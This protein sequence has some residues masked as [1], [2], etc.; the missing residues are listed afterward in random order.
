M[1]RPSSPT[2]PRPTSTYEALAPPP[3]DTWV[4]ISERP[5]PVSA[6]GEWAVLPGCGAAVTFTGT[7]R[8]H[9]EGR[10]GVTALT[11]ETFEEQAGP[12]IGAVVS[13]A[14]RRWPAVRRVA[15][16][17]RIGR[18]EVGD[19]AVVVTVSSPHRGDAFAAA[20][21]CIDT[22][23]ATVPIWKKE[24]WEGG[25]AWGLDGQAVAEVTP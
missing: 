21:Y 8:D 2:S 24:A 25:E 14:R 15:A 17:H 22:L 18:L 7:V 16:L 6:I 19:A 5:L 11:Y 12:R 13:E 4:A 10:P 20:E 9:A 1:S 3:G 23:K